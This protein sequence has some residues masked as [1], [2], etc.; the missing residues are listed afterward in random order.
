VTCRASTVQV[1]TGRVRV[2]DLLHHR[3]VIVGAGHE[4]RVTRG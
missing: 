2:T 1:L 4:L 3:T